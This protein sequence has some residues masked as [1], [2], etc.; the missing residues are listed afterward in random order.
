MLALTL[1]ILLRK[2]N[3]L[4]LPLSHF[5]DVPVLFFMKW[6]T[7]R[8]EFDESL[9]DVNTTTCTR[10]LNSQIKQ[11]GV[12]HLTLAKSRGSYSSNFFWM[13]C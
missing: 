12:V 1:R 3:T 4:T 6:I 11:A 13:C 8:L 9:K 10:I 7:D 2:W 5:P